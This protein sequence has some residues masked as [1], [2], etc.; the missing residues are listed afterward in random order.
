MELIPLQLVTSS[1]VSNILFDNAELKSDTCSDA[2]S[3][4]VD[5]V[6]N[7]NMPM[8]TSAELAED[9]QS[10]SGMICNLNSVAVHT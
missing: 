1:S 6:V 2:M 3:S 8:E 10:F 9:V 7:A 4:M 5:E